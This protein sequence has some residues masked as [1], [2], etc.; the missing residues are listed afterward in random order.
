MLVLTVL[1]PFELAECF[2]LV[3]LL[4]MVSDAGLGIDE[5]RG[6]DEVSAADDDDDF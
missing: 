6:V 2:L 3:K 1:R 4:C 5:E